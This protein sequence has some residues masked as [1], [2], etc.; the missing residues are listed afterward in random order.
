MTMLIFLF[1]NQA[2]PI[3]E[4]YFQISESIRNTAEEKIMK[5]TWQRAANYN[6]L[7]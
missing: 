3:E 1:Q 7:K 5:M 2:N 6:R 4:K